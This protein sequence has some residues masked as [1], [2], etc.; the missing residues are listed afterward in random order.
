M[1][2]RFIRDLEIQESKPIRSIIIN[3]KWK[4]QILNKSRE[5]RHI[6]RR[7]NHEKIQGISRR[8]IKIQIR[9]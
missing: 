7:Y 9:R 2:F 6:A 4:K 8:F 1:V 3:R 5:T